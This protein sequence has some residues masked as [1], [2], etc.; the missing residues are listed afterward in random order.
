M[1]I[2]DLFDCEEG[3]KRPRIFW[4]LV[5]AVLWFSWI[6]PEA[7]AAYD[8]AA[9]ELA[10][11]NSIMQ[12]WNSSEPSKARIWVIFFGLAGLYI[13]FVV[14]HFVALLH[15]SAMRSVAEKRQEKRNRQEQHKFDSKMQDMEQENAKQSRLSQTARSKKELILRLGSIDQ[16]VRVLEHETDASRRT[17]ALQAAH[18]EMT[19]L[20]AKL[21]SEEIIPD[22]VDAP[23]VRR[24]AQETSSDLARLGYGEDRLN[25]DIVRTFKLG[26]TEANNAPTAG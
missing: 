11:R 8:R 24:H 4:F 3:A 14:A 12:W 9:A 26:Q 10:N 1:S 15:S 25:R 7:N 6:I 20:T 19:T 16:F 22:M 5:L 18:S 21:A 17:V 13:V 2:K 23:E